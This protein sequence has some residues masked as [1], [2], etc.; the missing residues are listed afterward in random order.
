[1][2]HAYLANI[3]KHFGIRMDILIVGDVTE[4]LSDWVKTVYPTGQLLTNDNFDSVGSTVCYT[5]VVDLSSER[6]L[7]VLQSAKR[8]VY[9]APSN[10]SSADVERETVTVLLNCQR[11]V[12]DFN[13]NT[14]PNNMLRLIDG[15]ASE[16]PQLWVTG[17]SIADGFGITKQQKYGQLVA[18]QLNLPVSF[19]TTVATSI[20]WAADQLLRSKLQSGDTILWGLTGVNRYSSYKNKIETHVIS[21]SFN[22]VG[23]TTRRQRTLLE[24]REPVLE[25]QKE[26]ESNLSKLTKEDIAGLQSRL[27]DDDLLL[28]AIKSI[29]QVIN[30]CELMGIRL[31]IFA[32]NISTSEF[33]NILIRYLSQRKE[34]LLISDE[35]DQADD[36]LHPGP[37]T[38]SAWAN[39]ILSKL[40]KL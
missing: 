28:Y 39:Q 10:W 9:H 31:V 26:F 12:E 25:I 32:H 2:V 7:S 4:E 14:D 34:F 20:P 16:L 8:V 21:N 22:S 13:F 36:G 6:L 15:R 29:Y 23:V 5:S 17:C 33:H 3:I 1:M 18:D 19:L 11:A 40:E 37:K 30:V 35:I 27:L 38:N 24:T